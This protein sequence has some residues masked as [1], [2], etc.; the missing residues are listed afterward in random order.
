MHLFTQKILPVAAAGLLVAAVPVPAA[1]WPQYRGPHGDGISPERVSPWSQSGPR[2]LWSVPTPAGFSSFAVA[3]GK[4]YTVVA[5][6][7]AGTLSETCI[8]LDAGTGKEIWAAVT[9]VAKY[10]GGGDSGAADNKGGDG[11]RST[12]TV[13]DGRVYVFSSEMEL[14]C[15]DAATGKPIWKH[16]LAR[17][18][19]GKNIDWESALSPV[20]DGGL[21]FVAGGGAGQ[22]MLAFRK[23]TGAIAWKT[24]D[25]AMTHASP[26]IADIHGVR[27]LIFLMQSGAVSVDPLTGKTLWKQPFP[28]KVS[29][30]CPPVVGGNIVFL[31]AGYEVGGGAFEITKTAAGY[32][33]RELWR[34]K[35]NTVAASLWSPPVYRDGHLYGMISYKR[36]GSGPL[37]CLDL[38]TGEIKWEKTGYGNGNVILA[39]DKLIALSDDGHVS[40]V[41]ASPD[42]LKELA[43]FKAVSGKCWTTPALADG[44]LYVRSTREG[45]CFDLNSQ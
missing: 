22:S 4:A 28:H 9:G 23:E 41:Q 19:G 3:D 29:T 2:K 16:S 32:V 24:G 35:G 26:V 31:T 20:V 1:S 38:K 34:A 43:K 42:G 21:V 6:D 44:R 36:Y 25:E 37:K 5:R 39:G 45:A 30:A 33:P 13:S 17:E 8:C 15:L 10:P 27:Q 12:P 11:P 7:R 18:F 14:H 40:L